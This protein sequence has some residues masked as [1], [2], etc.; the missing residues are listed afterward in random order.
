M[1]TRRTKR[2]LRYLVC[3]QNAYACIH[4]SLHNSL[5]VASFDDV[6]TFLVAQARAQLFLWLK[7]VASEARWVRSVRCISAC[8]VRLQPQ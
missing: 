6:S 2:R 1:A 8:G 4:L 3:V 5:T 7:P